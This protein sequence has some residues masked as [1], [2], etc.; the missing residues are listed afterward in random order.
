MEGLVKKIEEI[1]NQFE[2]EVIGNRLSQFSMI[3][4]RQMVLNEIRNYKPMGEF[5]GDFW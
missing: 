3:T 1:L 5:M 2:R 4:L